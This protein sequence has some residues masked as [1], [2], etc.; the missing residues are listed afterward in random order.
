[1]GVHLAV[2]LPPSGSACVAGIKE[3]G[4]TWFGFASR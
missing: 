4:D 1:M 2:S 3:Y